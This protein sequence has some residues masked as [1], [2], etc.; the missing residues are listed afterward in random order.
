LRVAFEPFPPPGKE[1]RAGPGEIPIAGAL[2]VLI[3]GTPDLQRAAFHHPEEAFEESRLE[4]RT[5]LGQEYQQHDRQACFET[6][7]WASS[8]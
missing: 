1:P 5:T 2:F 7:L 3:S 8:A 6:A 4:G